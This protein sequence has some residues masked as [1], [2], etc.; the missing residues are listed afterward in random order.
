MFK[1]VLACLINTSFAHRYIIQVG[2]L[3]EDRNFDHL[4]VLK[5]ISTNGKHYVVVECEEHETHLVTTMNG[6]LSIQDDEIL[7][8]VASCDRTEKFGQWGLNRINQ[9]DLP[10]DNKWVGDG[11]S[12]VRGDDIDVYIVDSGI[13]VNHPVFSTPPT[14]F[15]AYG[16]DK[17]FQDCHG[18]G[19]HVAG[20]VGGT[21]V[22]VANGANLF[23]VRINNKCGEGGAYGSNMV[24]AIN[25]VK[26]AMISSGR[27]SVINLSYTISDLIKD[28]LNDFVAAGGNVALAAANYNISQCDTSRYGEL[29]PRIMIVGATTSSD[30]KAYFSNYGSCVNIWAP[31]L[32]INS[33][34]YYSDYCAAWAGTSMAAPHVAGAFAVYSVRNP[35]YT[36]TQ[37]SN[38]L[39]TEAV[40]DKLSG[41]GLDDNNVLLQVNPFGTSTP[42]TTTTLKPTTSPTSNPTTKPTSNPTSSPTTHEPTP[43]PTKKPY[44]NCQKYYFDRFFKNGICNRQTNNENCGYDGGDCCES[45]C[46]GPNCGIDGYQCIDPSVSKSNMN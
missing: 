18:H 10:L 34:T 21:N 44:L 45:T 17:S 41:L 6:V 8:P 7:E 39:L 25:A 42:S 3:N 38:L 29:D 13:N 46:I 40:S 20:T 36:N 28:A 19:T 15:G 30:E 33:A 43:E 24:T 1:L 37:L 32:L 26:D 22:G 14:W 9:P 16:T 4:N 5:T 12:E 2:D 27:K 35:S 31:G 23:A 11:I